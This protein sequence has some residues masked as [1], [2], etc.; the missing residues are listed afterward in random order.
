MTKS[1]IAVVA[2]SATSAGL[3]VAAISSFAQQV[4]TNCKY[5]LEPGGGAAHC[6]DPADPS[7]YL[8][9]RSQKTS[10]I[11]R[12]Q[13]YYA[14]ADVPTVDAKSKPV[15]DQ[16]G[17]QQK[18]GVCVVWQKGWELTTLY[19]PL[20]A[21]GVLRWYTGFG[22]KIDLQHGV[23]IFDEF[24]A[25]WIEDRAD[26]NRKRVGPDQPVPDLKITA[27]LTT[28]RPPGCSDR[29]VKIWK[30][31]QEIASHGYPAIAPPPGSSP[32]STRSPSGRCWYFQRGVWGP[33]GFVTCQ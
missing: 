5:G 17:R 18:E 23:A 29:W 24:A 22:Y 9:Y 13:S 25:P 2:A 21:E 10:A 7:S 6:A 19:V 20:E 1:L 26:G 4:P 14:Y 30:Q 27:P 12:G 8:Y 33:Y 15:A 3:L 11:V 28:Q 16:S 32:N 31:H